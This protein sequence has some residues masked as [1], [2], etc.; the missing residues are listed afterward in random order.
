MPRFLLGLSIDNKANLKKLLDNPGVA[1]GLAVPKAYGMELT[2]TDKGLFFYS[3]NYA[4]AVQNGK[5]KNPANAR[6]LAMLS[7]NDVGG[8]LKF[9]G[10]VA[11]IKQMAEDEPEAQ[12]AAQIMGKLDELS[13]AGTF[14][15][16]SKQTVSGQLTFKDKKTNGLKQLVNLITELAPTA[17]IN[18]PA[19]PT[20]DAVPAEEIAPT[21][22]EPIKRGDPPPAKRD[23]E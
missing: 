20:V 8:Y 23:D 5:V 4:E 9:D 7:Q 16:F 12:M 10:L 19:S 6:H 2:H 14:G 1:G 21:K 3:D 15:D 11:L 13:L 17:G 22:V 18:R